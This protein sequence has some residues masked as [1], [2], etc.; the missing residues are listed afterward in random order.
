M[1]LGTT[2]I[3]KPRVRQTTTRSDEASAPTDMASA[4][5]RAPAVMQRAG[6]VPAATLAKPD[7]ALRCTAGPGSS[8]LL[9][10]LSGVESA[11]RPSGNT[12]ALLART[13][14]P[15]RVESAVVDGT[16]VDTYLNLH[17][18]IPS[19]LERGLVKAHLRAVPIVEPTFIVQPGGRQRVLRD[20]SKVVH[21]FVRGAFQAGL[22]PRDLRNLTPVRVTYNPY[23][24]DTFVNADTEEPI[25]SARFAVFLCADSGE[26]NVKEKP[27]VI[28]WV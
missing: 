8:P 7:D 21:A 3:D 28:A 23:K 11:I 9:D 25:E 24:Y 22:D 27:T 2:E 18:H 10:V 15:A 13:L 20:R 4:Q 5:T 1:A 26:P 6:V 12:R 16:R 17:K 14:N 19:V